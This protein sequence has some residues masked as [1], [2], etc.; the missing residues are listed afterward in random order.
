MRTVPLGELVDFY[1]GGTPPK[2]NPQLWDGAIPW[3]SAKDLKSD[4]LTDSIDHISER[5]FAETS[6]KPVP[7]GTI[8]MVVRG[9]ILAHTVPITVLDV[10]AAINQD[11][12]ALLPKREIEASYLAAMLRAQHASILHQVSTAAHGTKKLDSRVLESLPIPMC[13]VSEQRRIAAILDHADALRAKRRQVLAH[14]DSLTQSIFHDMF[15]EPGDPRWET[16]RFGELIP[17][18]DNGSSPRCE[19]RAAAFDEW[20]VLKLGAVTYGVFQPNE[21]KAYLDDPSAMKANEVR[22]G[23]VLM[24][25]KNTRDLVGAVALVDAVRPRLLLPDLIFRLHLEEARLD[26]LYFH[27]LMM[28]PRKRS[29]VRDLSSGSAASMPNISKARLATLPLEVP[30]LDLQ[31]QFAARVEYINAQREVVR[32]A[33]AADDELFASLQSRAFRGEL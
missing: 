25:R 10:P 24:T 1:S 13:S 5:A 21:N 33:L 18:V 19:S 27:A 28:S 2:A 12:K 22:V 31:R 8:A 3:F 26:R 7:A 9:M 15:G 16:A 29:A 30:P 32:R 11:L 20:G 14:L 23:D 17:R 4:R 6:L